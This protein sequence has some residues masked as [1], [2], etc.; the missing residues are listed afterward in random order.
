L[1]SG[2]VPTIT[3]SQRPLPQYC[4]RPFHRHSPIRTVMLELCYV[5][6]VVES[7]LSEIDGNRWMATPEAGFIAIPIQLGDLAGRIQAFHEMRRHSRCQTFSDRLTEPFTLRIFHTCL[8]GNTTESCGKVRRSRK[9]GGIYKRKALRTNIRLKN[10]PWG[11]ARKHYHH[12][13]TE[14]FLVVEGTD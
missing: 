9:S 12:T 4:E 8:R 14:K 7:F 1:E 5:D 6:D 10:P 13:K 2:V 3:Q 11:N